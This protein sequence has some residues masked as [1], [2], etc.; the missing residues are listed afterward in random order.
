MLPE[1]FAY[2]EERMKGRGGQAWRWAAG[3]ALAVVVGAGVIGAC[4]DNSSNEE[5]EEQDSTTLQAAGDAPAEQRA[6]TS[7]PEP[8]ATAT[9]RPVGTDAEYVRGMCV[10]MDRFFQDV[11]AATRE[12]T[13]ADPAG[14][15]REFAAAFG[16]PL[17]RFAEDMNQI[18][19]PADVMAWHDKASED[20]G[21][22]AARIMEGEGLSEIARLG[23]RPLPNLPD[24]ISQRVA[25]AAR[26]TPE[27][28][29]FEHAFG[30]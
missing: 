14:V 16:P 20:L 13:P 27:C 10:A 21:R 15:A 1:R 17:A 11:E 19:P 26:A 29:Q 12:I 7:T 28:L 23:D 5:P 2:G 8:T 30:G 6:A 25:A 3:Y 4:S 18:A 24:G 9:P 22:I